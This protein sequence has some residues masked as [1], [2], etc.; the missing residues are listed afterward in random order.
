MLGF[1]AVCELS[2]AVGTVI[3]LVAVLRLLCNWS[4]LL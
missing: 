3:L 4:G 2:L 1:V